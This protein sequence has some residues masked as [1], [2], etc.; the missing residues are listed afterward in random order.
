MVH[1]EQ[2]NY[3]PSQVEEGYNA[4]LDILTSNGLTKAEAIT[5]LLNVVGQQYRDLTDMEAYSFVQA[6]AEWLES[7]F[8]VKTAN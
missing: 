1:D 4:I 3:A 6:A 2:I 8:N 7:Y 5:A